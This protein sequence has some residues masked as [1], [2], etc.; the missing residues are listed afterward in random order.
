MK[1]KLLGMLALLVCMPAFAQS[2]VTIY[3]VLD[4]G[5]TYTSNQGGKSNYFYQSGTMVPTLW[6]LRGTEDLGGGTKAIFRLVNN[7]NDG[8]GAM[9][10]GLLFGKEAWVG[11]TN[12]QYGT[13]TAGNQFDFMFRYMTIDR[14]GAMLK[15]N[16][17]YYTQQGP[18]AKLNLP[19]GSMDFDR[20]AGSITTNNAISYETP[21]FHGLK[22]GAMYAFG[23]QPGAF[24]QNSTQSFG[25]SYAGGVM[26]LDAA[27]TY[28]KFP[29]INNGNNGIRNWGI[30]GRANI[31]DFM[32][33]AMFTN[34][35]NTYNGGRVNVYEVGGYYQISDNNEMTVGYQFNQGNAVLSNNHAH[36]ANVTLA[37]D[38]SKL[39]FVYATVARQWVSGDGDAF[40]AIIGAGGT[41]SGSTQTLCRVGLTVRF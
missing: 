4:A 27:Y 25:V 18:F 11:L 9:V 37:H 8:T 20:T 1:G 6:G 7:F 33:D 5:I 2:S 24:G 40:A 32:I 41:S 15:Y 28:T 3:G 35:E 36:Q 17:V 19:N 23:G 30:G 39:T 38:F 31:A 10:N 34:T 16:P 13:V 29:N 14:W 22:F 12:E 21:N 26:T